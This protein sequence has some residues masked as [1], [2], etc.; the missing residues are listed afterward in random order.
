MQT[1]SYNPVSKYLSHLA[2]CD[3]VVVDPHLWVDVFKVP[4]KTPTLQPLP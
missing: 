1:V 4:A 2:V 3:G